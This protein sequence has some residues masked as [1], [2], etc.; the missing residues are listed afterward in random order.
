MIY[1]VRTTDFKGKCGDCLYFN[2]SNGI[3]GN[4]I[5]NT[6]KIKPYN[7]FRSYNSKACASKEVKYEKTRY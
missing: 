5:S 7:R 3:D 6:T 1:E 2:T 4:C